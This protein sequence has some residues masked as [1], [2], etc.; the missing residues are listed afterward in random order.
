MK[1]LQFTQTL[2]KISG[3]LPIFGETFIGKTM[4]LLKLGVLSLGPFYASTT[5]FAL[6]IFN[7]DD[8]LLM[9]TSLY[10]SIGCAICILLHFS[11]SFQSKDIQ[12]FLH[13]ME[14]LVN[15]SMLNRLELIKN[16]LNF[17]FA[18]Q[19]VQFSII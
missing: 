18:F 6:A 19:N 13:K 8:L 16:L 10:I 2:M 12:Q 4:E 14:C 1:I 11:H 3:I 7:L 17:Y 5:T 15:E 9:T